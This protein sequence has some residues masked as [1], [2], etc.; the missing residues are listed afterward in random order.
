MLWFR[1][2]NSLEPSLVPYPGGIQVPRD[3]QF[4]FY[5]QYGLSPL[6]G[7]LSNQLQW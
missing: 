1:N 4:R 7:T 2:L 6:D 3:S 5:R